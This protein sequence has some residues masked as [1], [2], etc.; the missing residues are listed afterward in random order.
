M[1]LLAEEG[2]DDPR[3]TLGMRVMPPTSIDLV[4]VGLAE[5]PGVLECCGFAGLDARRLHQIIDQR[6]RASRG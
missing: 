6:S 5:M 3:V 2:G 1:G 4:N